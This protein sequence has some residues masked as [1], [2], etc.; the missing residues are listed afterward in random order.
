MQE[1]SEHAYILIQTR[2]ETLMTDMHAVCRVK[3][4]AVI[5]NMLEDG[6]LTD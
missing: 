2:S 5:A 3:P 4:S 1:D 6:F